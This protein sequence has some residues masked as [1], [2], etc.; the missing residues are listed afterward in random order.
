VY[1]AVCVTEW[2]HPDAS[3]P[4]ERTRTSSGSALPQN[5]WC[6][7]YSYRGSLAHRL[8]MSMFDKLAS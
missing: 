3:S 2:C 1:E 7:A 4:S 8:E 5:Y 6:R